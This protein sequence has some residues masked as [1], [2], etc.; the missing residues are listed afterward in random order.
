MSH[1]LPNDLTRNG[2]VLIGKAADI[3]GVS[4]DTVRRWD[5]A[6]KLNSVRL[7]GKNRCFALTELDRLKESKPLKISAAAEIL[8]MSASTL[9]RREKAGFL[10]P[11]RG[12]AGERLYTKAELEFLSKA[13]QE[14]LAAEPIATKTEV[15]EPA[16]TKQIVITLPRWNG[17]DVKRGLK[18]VGRVAG[19]GLKN[20]ALAFMV[21]MLL[22]M[23]NLNLMMSKFTAQ[24]SARQKSESVM[25]RQVLGVEDQRRGIFSGISQFFKQIKTS[26]TQE[27]QDIVKKEE[28][29]GDINQVFVPTEEEGEVAP[30]KTLVITEST[31]LRIK[32]TSLIENLNA[33]F[34]QGK[35]PG[36]AEGDVVV[37]GSNN[38][39]TPLRITA[40]NLVGTISGGTGGAIVDGSIVTADLADSLI[41]SVK[42]SDGAIAEADLGGDSVTA[43]KIKDGE[44]KEAELAGDAVTSAKI[45]NDTI[46][47]GDL[48]ANLEFSDGDLLDL[49]AID[50]ST[51]AKMGLILPNVSSS[52]PSSPA[53]EEG[54]LAYDTDSNQVLVY[55]GSSWSGIGGSVTLATGGG[56]ESVAS[57]LTLLTSCTSG[58]ILKWSGTEWACG[59]D[60]SG[61]GGASLDSLTA[62][63][64]NGIVQDS[65]AYTLNWN[66]DFAAAAVD[67]GLNISESSASTL[68]T[69][70]QQ[71]LVEITTL[72]GSTAAPL[73][74][75]S[76]STDVGDIFINL[77]SAGDFEIRDAGTAFVT[78]S[79]AGL[80]TFASDADFSLAGSENVSLT[81]TSA[82]VDQLAITTTISD[83]SS[84]DALQ[85]TLTDNTATSGNARGIVVETGDGSATLDAAFAVNH[86]DTTQAMTAG[87]II[88]GAASTTITTAID[89]SDA[90]IGTALAIGSNNLTTAASTLASTE[91]DI[92]DSGIALSELTNSGPLTVTTVD[93]NG[94][95]IDGTIIGAA[96]AAAGTFTTL[97]ANT[98]AVLPTGSISSTEIADNT[99]LEADLKVVDSAGD[100]ECLTYEETGGDF[101]WQSCGSGGGTLDTGYNAGAATIIVD[102]YDV[103]W[104]LN[105]ATN[106]YSMVIDNTTVGGD[107]AKALEITTTG[108]G[109]TITTAID[110]SDAE[111]ATALA[112]GANDVSATNWSIAGASGNIDTAGTI[113]AGSS[114]IILTDATG[115]LLHD[116][117]VDCTDGQIL[118]WSTG[119][120]RWGCASDATGGGGATLQT[121]YGA[122]SGNTIT[123]TDARDIDLVL[124]DTDTDA[125]LD[126]GLNA[127][128]TVT[129]SRDST[130]STEAPAQ[131]LLLEIAD[132]DI[133][134]TAALSIVETAGNI[135]TGINLGAG[136]T[137]GINANANTIENIGNSGTDFDS[138]GGL[139]L[140]STLT[141]TNNT[142]T[143]T[144]CIDA[145]DMAA[146]AVDD[147]E[148]VDALTYTGA[149]T[150]TPGTTTDF[151]VNGD[152]DSNAQFASVLTSD[153]TS[154]NTL[155]VS[156]VINAAA[157]AAT[158]YGVNIAQADNAAN[159]AVVD[160]I[161]RIQNANAAETTATGL[162]I[163]QTGAGTLTNGIRIVE[164]AGAITN[165]IVLASAMTVGINAGANTIENIGNSG[166][167]FDGSGGLTLASTLTLSNN[168][169]TC[170]DCIDATDMAASSVDDSE[171]VDA[172]TYT[173]ALTLTPGSSSDFVVNGDQDSNVQ[174]TNVL[175][176]DA[177]S[178]NSLAFSTVINAAAGAATVYGVN[179]AQADNTTDTAVVDA[180]ARIQNANAAETT[181]NG[182]LVEQTG[183]GTLT[184]GVHVLGTA[185]VIT[186]G[187]NIEDGAGT[188]ADGVQFTGTFTNLVNSTNFVVTNAGAVTATAVN[189]GSG[190][191][192]T[193]GSVLGN[194][195]DRTTGGALTI[196]DT[197]ATSVSICNS[198]TCDTINFG[199]NADNDALNIGDTLDTLAISSTA[200]KV[201]SAGAISGVTTM[202]SSGDWDWTG[203]TTPSITV[204]ANETLTIG[205][206]TDTLTVNFGSAISAS[207]PFYN[208]GLRPVKRIALSPEYAGATL[209]ADTSNNTGSMTADSMTTSPY[210]NYYDWANTQGTVQDYDIWVRVPVPADFL[211]WAN[212]TTLSLDTWSDDTTNGPINV[213]VYDTSNAADCTSVA[214]T[215]SLASTWETKTAT[216][217]LDTG[218]YAA[219]GVMTVDIKLTAAATNGNT[220]VSTIWMDYYAAF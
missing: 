113:Q 200:F 86:T 114:N 199:N 76:T 52:S 184:S 149:L 117:L 204:N 157:G 216:T 177:T 183:A 74:I 17:W 191:V 193:T 69:Q 203:S 168:T 214:F 42:V 59:S 51:T 167:D 70:D 19:G 75:T 134:A 115:Y 67:S 133:T 192:Q 8:G 120:G 125:N 145:T 139:T 213:T 182:L 130:A 150:L 18:G 185:G 174:L 98:D 37:W 159:T 65:N 173:G 88:S 165:G 179:I 82:S 135:T 77:A 11:K 41:T 30:K 143:C 7:D 23:L 97:T 6:R 62:A 87:V 207:N 181:A 141:L 4:I 56:I 158:V 212:S 127:D 68:G 160:A 107:I 155:D 152:Q 96:S 166:T 92:L 106:D 94:G 110:L 102:A 147:S 138:S 122:T 38:Q 190:T 176:S 131:L 132:A 91:L 148:L 73:Q 43:S 71:A 61:S 99:I 101:E 45:S 22:M 81:N 29:I 123:T 210:R 126:I 39:I 36:E 162:L 83:T 119:G 164:S 27:Y 85:V 188:I 35:V 151:V 178:V 180:I 2:Y 196:G 46:S 1:D 5:K 121:A 84:V 90:E 89:V 31:M 112:L 220:R 60:N 198:G 50:H 78:F 197:T 136:L 80:T 217:C 12:N 16:K 209:T 95:N 64:A 144:G 187:I 124:D 47:A 195:I 104:Q 206:G 93:I 40:S 156:T 109:G 163:D 13:S 53:S 118:K 146:A 14:P 219:N 32:E 215:P 33:E 21:G 108:V 171:L 208:N 105:D 25:E 100:E 24:Y 186:D 54:Y 202:A 48:T 28:V 211:G 218:T 10:A 111:I 205:D 57:E 161:A 55:N 175:T 26:V 20:P 172:L 63:T 170:T 3:L 58:Q 15:V 129:I 153:A 34:L 44:V 169:L 194:A 9:R 66:W 128:N 49:S 103:T 72:S 142:L 79:D 201:T 137:T 140:A 116:S 189:A 154:V